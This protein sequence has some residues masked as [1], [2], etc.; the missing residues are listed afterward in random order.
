MPDDTIGLF[1]LGRQW[2][3]LRDDALRVF[4][5]VASAGAFSLG[6]ELEEF[7]AEFATFCGT[8][9]C[10]GVANGTVAIELALRALG[11]GPGT[12]VVTVAHTFVATVEAIAA[13]GARPVL[14]DID[15][16]TRC[17]DPA[18]LA[19][20]LS[21]RTVA[22]V[23]V[24]LYGHPAA[25]PAILETCERAGVAVVEDAAQAHGAL[26]DGRRAGSMGAAGCFSFYPTKNLGAMGDGGAV[27]TDD[28]DLAAAVRSLRH[29]GSAPGDANRHERVGRTERLDNLQAAMLRLKLPRLD[30]ENAH[31]RWVAECYREALADLPLGLP[32]VDAPGAVSVHHLFVVEVEERDRVREALR[33]EGILAGVHYPTP[34]HLQ[35]G[36]R[37]LGYQPGGLPASERAAARV[38][39]LPGFPGM[40]EAEVER[41]CGALRRAVVGTGA[42]AAA[43]T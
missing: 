13:T 9:C 25:M 38:L 39:S 29:H 42:D 41:V 1:D 15:P 40:R 20:A 26:L 14:V 5:H 4:E 12:E 43:A 35:P 33:G 6:S 16:V 8:S 22:V 11:A 2:P 28:E 34:V 32:P 27:V 36:W 10:V 21:P 31:R 7:E 19:G 23:P 24:H 18:A 37:H 17:M 3:P 30:E